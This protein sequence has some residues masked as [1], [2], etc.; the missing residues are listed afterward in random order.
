[1]KTS[2]QRKTNAQGFTLLELLVV[3]TLL[4]TVIA[5]TS[6]SIVAGQDGAHMKTSARQL[7][8]VLRS[9]RTRAITEGVEAGISLGAMT[10]G[11]TSRTTDN[12]GNKSGVD[13]SAVLEAQGADHTEVSYTIIPSNETIILPENIALS[14]TMATQRG[15]VP[16]RSIL[17][18]PDGSSTGGSLVLNSPGGSMTI[19][20]NWLTGEVVLDNGS[21]GGN[22]LASTTA[23]TRL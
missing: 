12:R 7:L 22:R 9:S 4:V 13:K 3:I 2:R 15:I 20:V 11:G 10:T 19:D 14:L 16:P 17:F 6:V 23:N 1:M 21:T 5:V 18:Y 8:S